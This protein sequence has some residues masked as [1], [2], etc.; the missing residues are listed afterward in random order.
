MKCPQ[1]G[2]EDFEA[3]GYDYGQDPETGYVD[4]GV[5]ARCRTCGH[6]ADV[7]DF[8]ERV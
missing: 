6:E 2:S 4:S 7:E 5:R 1:C 8:Q 3:W